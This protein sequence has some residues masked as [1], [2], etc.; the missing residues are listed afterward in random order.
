MKERELYNNL[1]EMEV[2]N[3]FLKGKIYIRKDDIAEFQ[4]LIS[5]IESVMKIPRAQLQ[6]A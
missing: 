5:L 2:Y 6:A 1:N 3:N 4:K